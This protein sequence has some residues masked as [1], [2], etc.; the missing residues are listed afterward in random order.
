MCNE[1]DWKGALKLADEAIRDAEELP[2]RAHDFQVSVTERLEG[3]YE[4]IEKNQHVTDPQYE[5]IENMHG[6]IQRWLN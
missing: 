1:C 5:A 2:E 4:T 6:G 3:I